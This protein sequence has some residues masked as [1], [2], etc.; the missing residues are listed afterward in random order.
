MKKKLLIFLILFSSLHGRSQVSN[1]ICNGNFETPVI[2]SSPGMYPVTQLVCWQTTAPDQIIEIWQTGFYQVPSFS[3]NQHLEMNANFV[4]TI[5][6][7]FSVSPGSNLII[8]FA[9]RGRAGIDTINVEFGPVGGPY[10][11]LGYFADDNTNWGYYTVTTAV[12][13]SGSWYSL[14][15]NSV[16]ATLQ[17]ASVGNF[18]DSVTVYRS[19]VGINETAKTEFYNMFPNPFS[20][21]LHISFRVP[22]IHGA[23]IS[24]TDLH[25]KLI[26]HQKYSDPQDE[27]VS[28]DVSGFQ[29][30]IYLMKVELDNAVYHRKIVRLE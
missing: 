21:E 8:S 12:P 18:I 13:N 15:F 1:L 30:G 6:Q 14:R 22:F 11:N 29:N 27:S 5:Y 20:Q 4:S 7:D 16:Y 2:L 24:I 23:A 28:I 3:G 10:L 26:F 17:L 25:G 19:M 9:H